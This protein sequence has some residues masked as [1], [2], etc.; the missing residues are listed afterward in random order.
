[1]GGVLVGA[2]FV[3]WA[4]YHW[5]FWFVSCVAFPVALICMFIVPSQIGE[6]ADSLEPN[7][8]KWKTL[9]LFGI[10]ILTGTNVA[11]HSP[12]HCSRALIVAF[13]L[14]IFSVTSGSTAGW[15]SS[16]V[17]V[18]LVISILMVVGFFYWETLL[19]ANEAAM[20]VIGNPSTEYRL[21]VYQ[22]TPDVVLQQLLCSVCRCTLA[23]LLV[24]C[25]DV[26]FQYYVAKRVQLVGNIVGCPHVRPSLAL[27]VANNIK[28]IFA[29]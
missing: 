2:F 19:P 11:A 28:H 17:L 18:L 5:V 26:H 21:I 9:D 13:I 8:A 16:M 22:T 3:Q 15:K 1:M 20:Y 25:G 23:V 14:F 12:L 6:T 24:E 4:S 29:Q 7:K 10:V 27:H